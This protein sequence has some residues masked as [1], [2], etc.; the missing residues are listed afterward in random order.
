M[1]SC[2]LSGYQRQKLA[3]LEVRRHF[4]SN[5]VVEAWNLIPSTVK[6]ATTVSNFKQNQSRNGESHIAGD[7]IG[8][9]MEVW[10]TTG[11]RHFLRGPSGA[12]G[13]SST[14]QQV[15]KPRLKTIWFNG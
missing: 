11:C 14:S 8:V 3:R 1:R 5:R 10:R 2:R 4:F 6:N 13:S 7:I 9:K 12:T 15:S